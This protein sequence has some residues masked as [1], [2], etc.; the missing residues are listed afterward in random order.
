MKAKIS[1][2]EFVEM[3]L[4]VCCC[5]GGS[6]R[7]LSAETPMSDNYDSLESLKKG[8]PWVSKWWSFDIRGKGFAVCLQENP[9]YSQSRQDVIAWR[10]E[11]NG[12]FG[13]VWTFRTAGVGPIEVEVEEG[14]G[15]VTV[16]S[17]AYSD[18]KDS[19][20]AFAHLG[21]TAG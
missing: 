18:L 9:S 2:N 4:F 14:K 7:A 13:L 3:C 11:A 20:I 10:K 17:K 1:R 8:I 19:V 15:F 21:A 12:S 16:K 6:Q 5:L